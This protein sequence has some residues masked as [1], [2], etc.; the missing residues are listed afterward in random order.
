MDKSERI[1][2]F[3]RFSNKT[4]AWLNAKI[5]LLCKQPIDQNILGSNLLIY[6]VFTAKVLCYT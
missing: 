1:L 3:T 4:Y 2:S 6:K 5:K